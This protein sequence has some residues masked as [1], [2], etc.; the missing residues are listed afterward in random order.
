MKETRIPFLEAINEPRLLRPLFSPQSDDNPVTLSR[1]QQVWLKVM[2]GC[3]LDGRVK[4]D[5]GW[6]EMDYW[7]ASQGYVEYDELGYLKIA[8]SF[9][10][11]PKE[12]TEAWG[13]MGIRAGKSDRLAATI[14][15]YEAVCGGHEARVRQGRPCICFQIAQD[16]KMAKYSLHSIKQTLEGMKFLKATSTETWLKNVT[17]D[18]I[19]LKNGVTIAVTPPTVKSIRGYDAPIAVLDEVAV[20]YQ[21]ADSANPDFEIYRQVSSRQAQFT[22][23]KIVGISSPWNR[24][25]I[26]FQRSEAGTDGCRIV[27]DDC[28]TGKPKAG[29]EICLKLREPHKGRLVLHGTTA[30]CNPI[31][32]KTWLRGEL[33]KDPRSFERECLARFQDSISGFLSSALIE[34][35]RAVGIIERPPDSKN[36]YIAAIDPAF[37]HDAFAFTIVH[38][39]P[40]KG[41]VQDYVR[42]WHD[43]TGTPLDPAVIFPEIAS[44]LRDYNVKTAFCDQYVIEALQFIA[45]QFGFGIHEVTFSSGSKAEMYGNLQQLLNQGKLVLLDDQ[46]T[47]NELKQIEKKHTQGGQ[48]QIAAP[49]GAYDDMATVMAI[50]AHEAIWLLPKKDATPPKETNI[51]QKH[52]EHLAA[53]RRRSIQYSGGSGHDDW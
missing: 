45:N 15:A 35:A 34:R 31:I 20:W 1:P 23:P 3:P 9:P 7:A 5:R 13:V 17:A 44:V 29:C 53:K 26:M 18:R 46:D 38:A 39:E 40:G 30:A 4:D 41:I 2:Y 49:T 16:I 52:L 36:F 10:Y 43:P 27:C 48:V 37:R 33:N 19:E 6:T 24:A 51:I 14:V 50:A 25:G 32:P 42:R 12:Y 21:D 28:R 22:H 8:K 47:I 11:T